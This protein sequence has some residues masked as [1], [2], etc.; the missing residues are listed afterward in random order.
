MPSDFALTLNDD[1]RMDYFDPQVVKI[2]EGGV[3][4][5]RDGDL[6]GAE[7]AYREVLRLT[8]DH[9]GALNLIGTIFHQKGEHRTAIEYLDKA[10]FIAPTNPDFHINRGAAFFSLGELKNAEE[11]FRNALSHD[12]RNVNANANLASALTEL[13]Q[14]DDAHHF[15]VRTCEL[16][17][18]NFK[19]AKRLGDICL[20]LEKFEDA[21]EA[22][23]ACIALEPGHAEILNNIGY[24][25]ERVD[26]LAKT[27]ECYR[28]AL[29][30][31]PKSPEIAN[32][33]G[34]I[35][36][37]LGRREEA[38]EFFQRALDA[39]PEDWPDVVKMAGTYLNFGDYERAI[40]IFEKCRESEG[41]NPEMWSSYAAALS[42]AGRIQDADRA[43]RKSIELA[44]DVAETWN[45]LGTNSSKNRKALDAVTEYKKAIELSPYYPEPHINLCLTLM[46]LGRI[47]EAYMYAQI[48]QNLPRKKESAFTNP[49]KIFRG[50]CDFDAFEELGDLFELIEKYKDSDIAACFL[51]VLSLCSTPE[52]IAHLVG[53]HKYWGEN[54]VRDD[55]DVDTALPASRR[56]RNGK[57]KLGFLSSDLRSHSVANF[58]LPVLRHYDRSEIEIHCY[59]PHE[60]VGDKTQALVRDL[61]DGFHVLDDINH[62]DAAGVIRNDNVDVLFELN[63]FTRDTMIKSL[64]YRPAPVQ[65]YWLGYPFTTGLPE[66]DHILVDNYFAPENTDWL[67]EEPLFMPEAWVCF[68]SFLDAT[69]SDKLPVER[70]GKLTFGTLNNPYKFTRDTIAVWA[71]IMNE[72]EDSEFLLVRPEAD[73]VVLQSKLREHFSRCGV[74]PERIRFVN[75]RNT[76]YVHLSFYNHIDIS[77]D[78]FP[79]TGGA[80][81]C[82]AIWMGVPV[83]SLVGPS[84]H[85]RVS[86][87]LLENAGCGELACFSL[88]EYMGKAVMLGNDITSLRE[89]RHNMRPAL[90]NSPLCQGERFA[91]NFQKV[92]TD[93]F[94]KSGA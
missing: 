27:E 84:M 38:S 76:P 91:D 75:N 9:P 2:F 23:N 59:A 68:D 70:D 8:I 43:F 82:D 21:I 61:A 83:I 10:I 72:F 6:D 60:A 78:S 94:E 88:D 87:S 65:I 32:N 73:S 67:T 45:N 66:M 1:D 42:A 79:Q 17:P 57:L 55:N 93:A 40:S 41:E 56:T 37:R 81:T 44:P 29:D 62:K 5:H 58:V 51:V 54:L 26:E 36:Q 86:Y 48:A 15:A 12:S 3:E 16:A 7:T 77:L 50:V 20:Q 47:D 14:P 22:F 71:T 80:T 92:V 25:Y 89:Y 19:Y 69:I 35:L 90:L 49:A 46:F 34:S 13:G 31:N 52:E 30:L 64:I 74:G 4:K 39:N 11:C 33:L 53:L 28:A 63:G 18:E 24:A 85:Q